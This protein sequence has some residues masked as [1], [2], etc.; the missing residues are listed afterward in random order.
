MNCIEIAQKKL[1]SEEASCIVIKND[2][3]VFEASGHG[4][5]PLLSVYQSA[6]E[7]LRDAFVCDKIIG[8]AAAIILTLGGARGVYGMLMSD[9]AFAYLEQ[10]HI[11]AY[12]KESIPHIT[13]RSG[14]GLCPLESSVMQIDDPEQAYCSLLKTIAALRAKK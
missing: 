2:E 6:P 10:R 3:I 14:T 5:S 7:K 8:K 9:A 4:V 13:N 12:Y 1:C 11:A